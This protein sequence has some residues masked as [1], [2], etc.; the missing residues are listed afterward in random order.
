MIAL[1]VKQIAI[2]LIDVD[3]EDV[4]PRVVV[5]MV[6]VASVVFR[7]VDD[8]VVVCSCCSNQLLV[9]SHSGDCN[10][11]SIAVRNGAVSSS[12]IM[13]SSTNFAVRFLYIMR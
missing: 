4:V 5:M 10:F 13:P 12:L 9:S 7:D 3:S 1:T 2:I 11:V 8:D 6:V